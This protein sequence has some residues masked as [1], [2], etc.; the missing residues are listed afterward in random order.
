MKSNMAVH[1]MYIKIQC[2]I[3]SNSFG[4]KSFRDMLM[5]CRHLSLSV[6]SELTDRC[7]S[8]C[9]V[10]RQLE[11]CKKVPGDSR[12]VSTISAEIC[13]LSLSR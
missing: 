10:Q 7:V 11:A 5:R 8:R 3:I 4:H 2:A 6:S 13:N 12:F 1:T 9:V